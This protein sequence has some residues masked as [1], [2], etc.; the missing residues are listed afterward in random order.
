MKTYFVKI[1]FLSCLIFVWS[2]CKKIQENKIIKDKWLVTKVYSS[3]FNQGNLEGNSMETLLPDYQSNSECCKY[4]VDFFEDGSVTGTYYKDNA[5][6]QVD[7]GSWKLNKYNEKYIQLGKY[8]NGTFDI[9]K[10]E[11]LK[12]QLTSNADSNIVVILGQTL[13]SKVIMDITRI[14]D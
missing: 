9:D 3:V 14:K 10:V 4:Y 2:A 12:Y 11:K 1:T 6:V 7:S 13:K 8:I 5:V